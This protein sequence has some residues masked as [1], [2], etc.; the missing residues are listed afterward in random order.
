MAHSKR[1][2]FRAPSPEEYVDEEPPLHLFFD[3]LKTAFAELDTSDSEMVSDV[4]DQDEWEELNDEWLLA[5]MSEMD[6]KLRDPDWLPERLQKKAE[7]RAK[8]KMLTRPR[9][10]ANSF[11]S[12]SERT[13][14]LAPDRAAMAGPANI[15]RHVL[16]M[17]AVPVRQTTLSMLQ[18]EWQQYPSS[19]TIPRARSA[20]VLSDQASSNDELEPTEIMD[21]DESTEEAEDVDDETWE[22]ELMLSA[23]GDIMRFHDWSEMHKNIKSDLKKNS[24]SFSLAHINKLTI[25]SNFETLCIKGCSQIQAS[26]EIARQW[27]KG[28]GIHFAR[29]M[30]ALV[31]HY[32][33]FAQLP[34]EKQG[35]KANAH[36]WLH[37]EAVQA[38][39]RSWLTAQKVG[40]VT[41]KKL[42]H[43]LTSAIF[44][45]L[46]I[47]PK[48]PLSV[49]TAQHW[50]LK[51]G[52]RHTM[53]QKGVYM[54][55]HERDNVVKYRREV[56]LPLMAQYE[57]RMVQY[58]GPEL[59]KV[60]LHLKPGEKRI[61]AQFH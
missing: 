57:A 22:D 21:L 42:Q 11:T 3:S 47:H 37:D 8:S 31:R 61:I 4:D 18:P 5:V 13:S 16:P 33:I 55:G 7:I 23:G 52:W 19:S 29:K 51:L 12:Q 60:E 28:E 35:G 46:G 6:N 53:V 36:S 50:L 45:D 56:F 43:A 20:S 17:T 10:Y 44:L 41:L 2:R 27:H 32:Q 1:P 39:T 38:C 26:I 25:L 58:E 48:Q 9:T 34:V 49:R 15:A 24:K 40:S 59:K 30:Q 14:T 54:D